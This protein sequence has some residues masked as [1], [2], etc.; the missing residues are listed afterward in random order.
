MGVPKG[1]R[2]YRELHSITTVLAS[3]KASYYLRQYMAQSLTLENYLFYQEVESLRSMQITQRKRIYDRFIDSQ[4]SNSINID[5][6]TR[7]RVRSLM[8]E[9]NNKIPTIFDD[10]QNLIIH[11]MEL[12][13]FRPFLASDACMKFVRDKEAHKH[14]VY[15]S[16]A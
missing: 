13:T 9:T 14:G 5:S 15:V 8:E 1:M 12:N 4:A 7:H 3:R 2:S 10:A 16:G 11:L 6:Q